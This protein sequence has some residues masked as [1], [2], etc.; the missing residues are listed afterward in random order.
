MSARYR[1]EKYMALVGVNPHA[2]DEEKQLAED[3]EWLLNGF[4]GEATEE[5]IRERDALRAENERLRG[6][7]TAWREAEADVETLQGRIEK[8]TT[9]LRRLSFAA[10]TTGGTA[11]RDEGLQAAIAEATAA[12]ERKPE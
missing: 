3:I 7:K 11:G 10:Q 12:L 6:A 4:D 9:A 5:A 1:L 8:L 2:T